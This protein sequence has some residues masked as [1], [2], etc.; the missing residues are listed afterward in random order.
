MKTLNKKLSLAILST[1]IA[2]LLIAAMIPAMLSASTD[3]ITNGSFTSDTSSWSFTVVAGSPTGSWDSNG[4]ANGGCAKISSEVGRRMDG[5]GYWEQTISTTIEADSTVKLSYAWKKGYAVKNPQQQDIYVTIVKPDL[6]T[7]DID[8]RTGEPDAYDT[9]YTVSDEDVSASFDQ[10]GTYKIRLR[11]DYK[12]GN[13]ASAQAFAWF[14]EVELVVTAAGPPPPPENIEVTETAPLGLDD[15]NIENT[16]VAWLELIEN[17]QEYIDIE[18]FYLNPGDPPDQPPLSDIYDALIEAADNRGVIVRILVDAE[19]AEEEEWRKEFYENLDNHANITVLKFLPNVTLHSKWMVVDNKIVS[20]GSTNWGHKSLTMN[21]EINLTIRNENLADEYTY[22]FDSGW[23]AAGGQARGGDYWGENWIYAVAN[24]EAVPGDIPDT[25]EEWVDLFDSAQDNVQLYQYAYNGGPAEVRDAIFDAADRGVEI[26][27]MVPK[28]SYDRWPSATEELANHKNIHVKIMD[29]PDGV[30]HPKF[31]NVDGQR[32]WVGSA[33]I[34]SDWILTGREVGVTVYHS[35]T[36]DT[37]LG[38]FNTDWDS[39]YASW[40]SPCAV[41]VTPSPIRKGDLPGETLEFDITVANTGEVIDNYDLEASDNAGWTVSLSDNR[42]EGLQPGDNQTVTLSVTISES[43]GAGEV[44]IVTVTANSENDVNV[45]SSAKVLA[46]ASDSSNISPT[47]DSYVDQANPNSIYG[48]ETYLEIASKTDGK[49]RS[50]LKFDLSDNVPSDALVVG[51]ELDL[52]FYWGENYDALH[53]AG[54]LMEARE[55]DDDSWS[56]STINWNNA[57]TIGEVVD[58]LEVPS[59]GGT[60]EGDAIANGSF[61][62]NT[63][64][65]SFTV[66]DGS[67]TD[68]WDSNGYANG[69]CA[70]ISSEVGRNKNGE[71]YWEQTISETIEDGSTVKLSYAWKKGYAAKEPSQ[72]DIYVTIVKP[73]ATTADIDSRLGAPDAYDTWYPVSDEDVS[74]AFDQTGT[75]KI[76]LRYDYKNGNDASAQSFAWFDEVELVVTTSAPQDPYDWKKW[77]VSGYVIEQFENESD[78]LASIAIKFDNE[79]FDDIL[80]RMRFRSEEYSDNTEQR[81][82][83]KVNYFPAVYD[84]Q[85]TVDKEERGRPAGWTA[86]YTVTVANNG[87][88][89]DD[90]ELTVTDNTWPTIADP[91]L[92]EEVFPGENRSV[93]VT[94]VV[95]ADAKPGDSDNAT[96]IATSKTCPTVSDNIQITTKV[97]VDYKLRPCEDD[98]YVDEANSGSNYGTE[99]HLEIATMKNGNKRTFLKFELSKIPENVDIYSARLYLYFYWGSNYVELRENYDMKIE[100]YKVLDDSWSEGTLTWSNQPAMGDEIDESPIGSWQSWKYWDIESYFDEQRGI[101]NLASFAIKFETE[102]F[103]QT[104][105]RIRYRSKEY[106]DDT[107]L[108]PYLSVWYVPPTIEYGVDLTVTPEAQGGNAGENLEYDVEVKNLGTIPDTFDLEATSALGWNAVLVPETLEDVLPNQ[109]GIATLT[110]TIPESAQP[111]DVDNVTV[112]ATS[113]GD[114][115]V[116]D[117]AVVRAGI[118]QSTTLLS[119]DD[120]SIFQ[121]SPGSNYG[122][123]AWL[124]VTSAIDSNRRSLLKF[125][126]SSLPAGSDVIGADLNLYF[127]WG[128]GFVDLRD[129]G[130]LIEAREILND[131]WSE[132]TVTW[133]DAPAFGNLIDAV[134]IGSY[135]WKVW[136][137]GNFVAQQSEDDDLA[138][139]GIKFDT[140]NFDATLRRIRFRS[141][142]YTDNLDQRP[143]LKVDYF[144]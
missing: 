113:L 86:N 10:T 20:V 64:S 104:L 79:D 119:S 15:P 16:H 131:N 46:L 53:D 1:A 116:S 88:I 5:E 23:V 101:D 33:N 39:A 108:T 17:S 65:W 109:T 59:P 58:T 68:S 19:L 28:R 100:A 2:A 50:F 37:L 130:V 91:T 89:N 55:V 139:F 77:D 134:E 137:V 52:Y 38:V 62:N 105:R 54:V 120:S 121:D 83:L 61:E 69:G 47:D 118:S 140:E 85:V 122:S 141:Q 93:K 107:S 32:T 48:S 110:V 96:I 92:L 138:S 114:N 9:W 102:D 36:V 97:I 56:E 71:G 31:T 27:F 43:A 94:V 106:T 132:S 117:N 125:D 42:L 29:F 13:N 144:P 135:S 73:D 95:P 67:P 84:V 22:I 18:A 129:A 124:E 142:E 21:R 7:A 81:P 75:Y 72:Q 82:Y 127:Y 12:T 63:D 51:A 99:P 6:T 126:L 57:P 76:R 4:Y 70:K 30:A 41:E 35:K 60:Q 8:S 80:R 115:T 34:H 11:Y 40:I 3:V 98:S 128:S 45:S 103:D 49:R 133:N 90:Y 25:V 24:G 14:D 111:G 87:N 123:E 26:K 136:D 74:A 66:V 78:Q 44:S 143:Y 112:T